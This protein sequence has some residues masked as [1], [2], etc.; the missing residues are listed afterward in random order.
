MTRTAW[1]LGMVWGVMA[2]MSAGGP[3]PVHAQE[4][5]ADSM[6]PSK[7]LEEF[8]R[9]KNDN[10]EKK[11]MGALAKLSKYKN[12]RRVLET[13]VKTVKEG[14][15]EKMKAEAAKMISTCTAF[16]DPLLTKTLSDALDQ[17][18]GKDAVQIEICNAL[19]VIGNERCAPVLRKFFGHGNRALARAAI[20]AAGKIKDDSFVKPLVDMLVK[21][22]ELDPLAKGDLAAKKRDL[23][24]TVRTALATISGQNYTTG[25]EFEAWAQKKHDDAVAQLL[26]EF[27]KGMRTAKNDNDRAAAIFNLAQSPLRD[28]KILAKIRGFMTGGSELIRGEAIGYVALYKDDKEAARSLLNALSANKANDKLVEKILSAIAKMPVDPWA[29]SKLINYATEDD[30]RVAGLAVRA[31]AEQGTARSVELMLRLYAQL[32][33]EK[34]ADLRDEA[35]KKLDN[36]IKYLE[37]ALKDSL[38]KMADGKKESFEDYQ[39]WWVENRVGYKSPAEREREK[40]LAREREERLKAKEEAEKAKAEPAAPKKPEAPVGDGTG[41]AGHYY[42]GTNFRDLKLSRVDATIDFDFGDASGPDPA[43]GIDNYCVRWTGKLLPQFTETY[44]FHL[45]TDD[46]CRLWVNGQKIIDDWRDKAADEVVGKIDLVAGQKVDIKLEYYEKGGQ[47]VAKLLWSSPST[48]REIIPR[49]QLFPAELKPVGEPGL[50]HKQSDAPASA[51]PPGDASPAAAP[52]KPATPPAPANVLVNGGLES[53]DLSGWTVFGGEILVINASPQEGAFAAQMVGPNG[54][55]MSQ[56]IGSKIEP[57]KPYKVTAW[58][59]IVPGDGGRVGIDRLRVSKVGDLSS[60]DFGEATAA[61]DKLNEWQKL[62]LTCTLAAGDLSGPVFVGIRH[63]GFPGTVHVD[64]VSVA[65]EAA[66]N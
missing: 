37:P 45:F 56:P 21:F 10:D 59:K 34:K 36:K 39:R 50:A 61:A 51:A 42:A 19:A 49:T 60:A 2:A 4:Q 55:Y 3:A 43:V 29:E 12:D 44:T 48:P 57:G 14:K 66:A 5:Q 54:M 13:L 16:R 9:L 7:D 8:N 15:D 65:A 28:E 6:D 1:W 35:K 38:G 23:A 63:F 22:D 64:S 58:I 26:D 31:L 33:K 62:E 25:K 47:A 11:R 24:D 46:G 20:T 30:P 27:A 18:W 17:N 41:L 52:A 53:S 32:E 40:E